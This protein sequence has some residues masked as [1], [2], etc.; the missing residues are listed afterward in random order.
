[1]N[2]PDQRHAL[3]VARTALKLWTDVCKEQK[4]GDEFPA[5]SAGDRRLLLKAALLHDVGKVKGDVSTGDKIIAVLL[6]R[7]FPRAARRWGRLGRGHVLNNL[8]HALYI[9]YHH[10]ERSAA[11]LEACDAEAAVV[12][13]VRRHHQAATVDDP[14]EL[15]LLRQADDRH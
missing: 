9:Y 12:D 1:M 11:M 7:C 3:N 6:D 10:A 8:R 5:V 4:I 15:T 2:I 13:L 14:P